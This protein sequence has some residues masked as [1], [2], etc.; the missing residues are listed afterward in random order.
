[1]PEQASSDGQCFIRGV[2]FAA[3]LVRE[4]AL[5]SFWAAA[6]AFHGIADAYRVSQMCS[7]FHTRA[8]HSLHTK[9]QALDKRKSTVRHTKHMT[10]SF[11]FKMVPA[12]QGAYGVLRLLLNTYDS[13]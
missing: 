8:C 13:P 2:Y 10:H 3:C 1:M 11:C 7:S 4:C 6:V 9:R 12:V 5:T